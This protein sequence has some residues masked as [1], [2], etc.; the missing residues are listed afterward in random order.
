MSE[1]LVRERIY[2]Y[3]AGA[4]GVVLAFNPVCCADDVLYPTGSTMFINTCSYFLLTFQQHSD[5]NYAEAV[6][7]YLNALKHDPEN[8]QILRDLSLLQVK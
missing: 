5:H 6:K 2:S 4:T 7:C 8:L 1:K 3:F